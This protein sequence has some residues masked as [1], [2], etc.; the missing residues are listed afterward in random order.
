MPRELS[1]PIAT[2][3]QLLIFSG[4]HQKQVDEVGIGGGAKEAHTQ[5]LSA[6][7]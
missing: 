4:P 1:L 2:H 5:A 3:P 6:P 7:S